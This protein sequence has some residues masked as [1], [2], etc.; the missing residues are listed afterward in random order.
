MAPSSWLEGWY[1]KQ[2]EYGDI[3]EQDLLDLW[4]DRLDILDVKN[5]D[6]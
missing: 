2:E 6:E 3:K 1:V 5:R 4:D